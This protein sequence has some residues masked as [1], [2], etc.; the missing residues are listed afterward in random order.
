M[1][2][3]L[4]CG[5]PLNEVI[6]AVTV[7]SAKVLK[8]NGRFDDWDKNLTQATLFQLKENVDQIELVDSTGQTIIPEELIVPCAVIKDG[9]LEHLKNMD[10]KF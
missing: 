10:E 1:S 5:M 2:K 9:V 6:R 4:A 3:T 8:L 7:N